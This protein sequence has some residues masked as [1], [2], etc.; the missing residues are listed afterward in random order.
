ME[1]PDKQAWVAKEHGEKAF[2]VHENI[3]NFN[4]TFERRLSNAMVLR[5][6]IIKI[7]LAILSLSIIF[8]SVGCD[9]FGP[10]MHFRLLSSDKTG[11]HFN[12]ALEE[13][14]IMNIVTYPDFYSGG[15]VSVGDIDNDGLPDV[16]FTGNQVPPKLYRNLGN[17][18]FEDITTDA[19]LGRLPK[20]WYTGTSMADVNADGFLDIYVCRSGMEAPEDRANLLLINNGDGT[21]AERARD[22]GLANQGFGVNAYFL[23]YDKDGDLDVYVANQT[24]ARLNSSQASKLRNISDPFS[25]DKLYENTGEKFVDVTKESGLYS[26]QIGFAHGISVGDINDDG[27]EDIFVSN[28]FFEYDYLYLNNGDKT[29]TESIKKATKHISFFSMGNDMADFNN[30]GLLDIVVLDMVAEDNRRLYMNTGG[31]DQQRFDRI[32]QNGLHYQYMFNV[33]HMNNGNETFSEIGML[34]GISRTDWSWAPLFADFDNDGFKDLF[35]SN[36]LRKDIRNIDW[37]Y[38][39]RNLTQFS[40]LNSIE[41]SQWDKLLSTMPSEKIVNYMFR[42]N[43]D[44]TF[45]KVMDEWGLDEKSFSNGAAYADLDRDGDLDL[46]INNVDD[47]AFIWENKIE[48]SNYI[49]FSFEGP[50]M[51]PMALGAKVRIFHGGKVQYQQ[52]YM[53]RGYRSSVDPLMHFGLGE[54]TLVSRVEVT[55]PDGRVSVY[56]NIKSNRLITLDY[57]RT[58]KEKSINKKSE[59][60]ACFE[61]VTEQYGL[62][63]SHRENGML[64]FMME[65]MLPYKI[66]SLGPALAVADVNGDGLDDFYLGGSIGFEGQLFIQT[67]SG[68][69]IA[70]SKDEF[71]RDRVFEDTGAA[72]FDIDGDGDQDLYVVSGSN[73]NTMREEHLLDRLYINDGNG[74]FIRDEHRIPVFYGSGSVARPADFDSDGDIDLFIGGRMILGKYPLPADSYLFLNEGGKLVNATKHKASGFKNLGLVTDAV[75]TDYDM[76]GDLDLAVV[77]EWIPV[78]FFKNDNGILKKVNNKSNGLE[79]SSGWWW[80]I[81][82]VDIDHDGDDD[83]IVGNIGLNYKFR[84]SV[85]EPLELY[86][87]DVYD[88]G[89]TDFIIGYHQEGKIYPTVVRAKILAQNRHL[90]ANIPTNDIFAVSTLEEIYGKEL[91]QKAINKKI[92]TLAS[93]YIEN[94]G[95]GNFRFIP[96]DNYAQISNINSIVVRD[97]DSDGYDDLILV[98]NLYPMEAETIRNDASI[99][100]WMRGDGKGRFRSVPFP[101]SGLYIDGDVRH[102]KIFRTKKE[103]LLLCAK[104]NE[105]M[106]L[107]RI[108]G[109]NAAAGQ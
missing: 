15:G 60:I 83:Y 43:G 35:V 1:R 36:G 45:S 89:N 27:W 92:Y 56:K 62:N 16:F 44:L 77:G 49:Q 70:S 93:G 71:Y 12:N 42:N 75:W 107:V 82:A 108:K 94:L 41:D 103:P 22:Y 80:R 7:P 9:G 23:D 55:W 11:I 105:S 96:F 13:S 81:E 26:S 88:N 29:F 100:V 31:H 72:F 40:D 21:F 102:L 33:L 28:D 99:G 48:N 10:E 104:N 101:E 90:K 30:D 24:S 59:S 3:V 67:G 39:Y 78:T 86:I 69:F 6:K 32:V 53:A 8:L 63:V 87:Y 14:Y 18:K 50:E 84:P 79:H 106:Q 76:D 65:P 61:D 38:F 4:K 97:V 34:A 19:G 37:G 54:D 91:L 25:G 109:Q 95:N 58:G 68:G 73:E 98:G 51:N 17:M 52:H 20:G 57:S 5:I 74:N 64:D 46:I 2:C 47:E 66:S 85:K